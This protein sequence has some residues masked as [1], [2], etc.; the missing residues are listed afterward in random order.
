MA[1]RSAESSG[2]ERCLCIVNN[3]ATARMKKKNTLM[4]A[5]IDGGVGK[6]SSCVFECYF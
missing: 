3:S 2:I 4:S 5:V 6:G 1:T